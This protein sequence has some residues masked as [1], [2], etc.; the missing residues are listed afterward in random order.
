MPLDIGVPRQQPTT[1][2]LHYLIRTAQKPTLYV[3]EPRP[4]VPVWNGVNDPHTVLIEDGRGREAEFTLDRNGFTL[5]QAPTSVRNFYD[6]DE[7]TSVYYP[8]V[9]RLLRDTLGASRVVVFNHNV[10][11]GGRSD[12]PQPSRRVHNDH[13]INS[14][15]RRVR[16]HMGAEAEELLKH[17]FGIVN[18]WRPIR[19]PVLDSPLAL[20]DVMSFSDDDLIASDLVYQHV[21][22]ETSSVE[23]KPGHRWYYFS[24]QQPNEVILIRVHDSANDGRA[25]LSFHTSFENPLAPADAPPRESIEVRTLVFFPPNA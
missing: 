12:L 23:F 10:R 1:A 19:G 9:E 4:G 3:M 21:H 13:T 14:A 22:G 2:E 20:C 8:E 5:I 18:V 6:P 11:N 7:I 25:R 15:P 24:E 16:D 17:R